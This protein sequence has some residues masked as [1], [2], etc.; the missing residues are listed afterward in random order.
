MAKLININSFLIVLAWSHKFF[1]LM[2]VYFLCM[3]SNTHMNGLDSVCPVRTNSG[4][5]F[6][7]GMCYQVHNCPHFYSTKHNE[8]VRSK[9]GYQ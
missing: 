4:K 1:C 3:T 6:E 9:Y 2:A 8:Y 5:N 7:V